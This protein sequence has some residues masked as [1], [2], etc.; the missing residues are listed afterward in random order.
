[1][2]RRAGPSASPLAK[3]REYLMS[4]INMRRAV[5]TDAWR[6][7]RGSLPMQYK[8]RLIASPRENA[9]SGKSECECV[10]VTR[11]NMYVFAACIQGPLHAYQ[12]S[13]DVNAHIFG[14]HVRRSRGST[15]TCYH[16][17][18]L[19]ASWL[20]GTHEL[21]PRRTRPDS[22]RR[23]RHKFHSEK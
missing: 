18:Y 14:H 1:M 17:T 16:P 23:L 2:R 13:C 10:C 19:R 21:R 20:G 15:T 5:Q 22:F 6:S 8:A 11:V 4:S 12:S 9:V 3:I 7:F